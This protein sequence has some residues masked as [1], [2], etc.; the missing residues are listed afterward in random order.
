MHPEIEISVENNRDISGKFSPIYPSTEK[1]TKSGITNKVIQ[2]LMSN[3]V[4][5]LEDNIKETLSDDIKSKHKLYDLK[6][7][8]ENVHFPE[9]NDD[10]QKSPIKAKESYNIW[11]LLKCLLY[12]IG[13]Y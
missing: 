13:Y 1:L 9:N 2:K 12:T 5:I 3:L 6:K 7:A 8:Y 11:M 10:L 4:L